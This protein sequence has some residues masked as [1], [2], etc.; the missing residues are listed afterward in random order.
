MSFLSPNC[1]VPHPSNDV[2]GWQ[3]ERPAGHDG[4]HAV[5]LWEEWSDDE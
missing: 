3:C 2:L 5:A 4:P 1:G